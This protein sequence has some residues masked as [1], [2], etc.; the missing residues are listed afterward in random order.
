MKTER[1]TSYTRP[2][3]GFLVAITLLRG[4]FAAIV[5]SRP[6]AAYYWTRSTSL[7]W[8]Y[9]DHGPL[10]AWLI[11]LGT[12][13]FGDSELGV[14]FGSLLCSC[15]TSWMV[16]VL[17][18]NLTSNERHSF[19]IAVLMSISPLLSVGAVVHTPDA[20]LVAAWSLAAWFGLLVFRTDKMTAWIGMG[21]CVG[22]AI[23]SKMTGLL[24][25]AG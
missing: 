11:R 22:L 21:A 17:A 12:A 3:L 15:L 18:R 16:F 8:G 1:Q 24:F 25:F 13:L 7:A 20:A 19:W 23:L 4:W 5:E 6:D 14:R 2:F 9:Y 10:V